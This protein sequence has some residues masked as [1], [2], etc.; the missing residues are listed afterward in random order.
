[1]VRRAT[2]NRF[3]SLLRFAIGALALDARMLARLPALAAHW[4]PA[5]RAHGNSSCEVGAVRASPGFSAT[6]A[7]GKLLDGESWWVSVRS[8]ATTKT[9]YRML[10]VRLIIIN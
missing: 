10:D 3:G 1:M 8:M 7:A 2:K 9:K 6:G 4:P 5:L